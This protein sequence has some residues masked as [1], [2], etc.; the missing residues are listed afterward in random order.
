[1]VD[2]I[3]CTL[4]FLPASERPTLDMAGMPALILTHG[5]KWYEGRVREVQLPDDGLRATIFSSA[6]QRLEP[7]VHYVAWSLLPEVNEIKTR[8][9]SACRQNSPQ[10][11]SAANCS[12]T[13]RSAGG[14]SAI[15][16]AINSIIKLPVR[17]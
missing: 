1:M 17:L 12:H 11:G 10:E 13:Y 6:G 9:V 2:T 15:N 7:G 16:V 8:F 14:N 3:S 4:I 5:Q